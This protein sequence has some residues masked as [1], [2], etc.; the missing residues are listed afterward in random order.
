MSFQ[1][2]SAV[3]DDIREA[4]EY[5]DKKAGSQIAIDFYDE[6]LR[7]AALASASPRSYRIYDDD[8]TEIRRVNLRRFPY[9]FLYRQI[10]Q[11]TIRI[12]VIRH[13]HRHPIYGLDRW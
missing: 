10:D 8:A 13:D 7:S 6:F 2:N 3:H 4:I 1:L 5:Y 9:H 12:L 11:T